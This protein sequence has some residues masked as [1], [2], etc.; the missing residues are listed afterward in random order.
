MFG[1]VAVGVS[2]HRAFDGLDYAAE[3]LFN[4]TK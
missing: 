2:M 1:I 3:K 4:Q